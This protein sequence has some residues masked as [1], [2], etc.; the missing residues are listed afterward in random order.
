MRSFRNRID[1]FKTGIRSLRRIEGRVREEQTCLQSSWHATRLWRSSEGFHQRRMTLNRERVFVTPF[2]PLRPD[3]GEKF[4][5]SVVP[6]GQDGRSGRICSLFTKYAQ[7]PKL[8]VPG[9]IPVSRS[10]LSKTY[11]NL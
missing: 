11:K 1:A 9:S 5:N 4:K 7:I 10:F 2:T 8:D 3:F 6:Y